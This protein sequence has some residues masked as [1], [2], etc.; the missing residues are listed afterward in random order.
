MTTRCLGCMENFNS[1]LRVCPHCGYVIGTKAE[2]AIHIV[3]GTVIKERYTIGKVLGYGGFGVTYIGWD[4]RLEQKVAI[5]EYLPSEF[6]TRMPGQSRITVFGGAKAEQFGDGLRKFVDEAKRLANF[7]NEYG[8]VKIF[9]S[10]LENDTAYIVME[11]LDGETLT[12]F[13]D[14]VGV[15]QEEEAV[16][17]LMPIMNS[18]Q[19]VHEIGLLH[20]DIAPDNIFLTRD[21][22]VK[23]IDFGASRFA[24]TSHSRSLTAI[25]K[26]G[27]SPEEQYRS[28]GDQ[29]PHTDVYAL[30]ATLYRMITGKRPP[31][32]MGRREQY[33]TANKD[34]LEAPH[35]YA[36]KISRAR[37]IAILNAM[38]VR[39]EDRTATV[40]DFISELEAD[41]PAKRRYGKIKKIDLYHWPLWL[42][43]LLPTL[44]TVIVAF[45][46][47]LLTGVIDFSV[48]VNELPL[49][50][51]VVLVPNVEQT[52]RVSAIDELKNVGLNPKIGDS[53]ESKYVTAGYVVF[54]TPIG[55]SYAEIGDE[56]ELSI[57]YD[58][59][60]YE[61]VDNIAI[62]PYVE[63]YEIKEAEERL[64]QSGLIPKINE[65]YSDEV[66]KGKVISQSVGVFEETE[67]NSEIILIVSKGPEPFELSNFV[68]EKESKEI[69]EKLKELGLSFKVIYENSEDVEKGI[70]MEQNPEAGTEVVRGEKI[71]LVI[72]AGKSETV[73]VPDVIGMSSSEAETTLKNNDFKVAIVQNYS[74]SVS[75][76][77]VISTSL[78][79]GTSQMR[80]VT[81]SVFVS[82]GKAPEVTTTEPATTVPTTTQPTTTK[83]TTTKPTTTKPTTTQPTT[84]IAISGWVK[85]SEVPAGGTVTERKWSYDITTKITSDK[86]YVDGY[87]LYDTTTSWSDYGPW[88]D[89]SRTSVTETDSRD[90][91]YKDVPATYKTQYNY[92]RYVST[93]GSHWAGPWKGTWSGNYCHLYQERGWSDTRLA[94]TGRDGWGSTMFDIFG[95]AGDGSWYNETTRSVKTADGY[96]L[97]CYRDRHLIYTYHH[98]KVESKESTSYPSGSNISNV[99]EWVKYSY[100]VS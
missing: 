6:S 10:F 90:V 89:W 28:R 18:L 36:K 34:I 82:K 54:Q 15:L 26:P 84:S 97:Y 62:V 3:P 80:G 79:S 35:K 74:E 65:E 47:L 50:D 100:V 66:E 60:V 96:R 55:G 49:A 17:M 93:D 95:G 51:G 38:N 63:N 4:S 68:G 72:S 42:K 69:K 20:R 46:G 52:D 78:K 56:I 91:D 94:I 81:I 48:F 23:L 86:S 43:V 32:A 5:K 39:I 33:E 53:F 44:L 87:N 61:P 29:G 77:K 11:Y 12:E 71:T 37:E 41:P 70:I 7:K 24:T 99:Q 25:I 83:P 22:G 76:G 58:D 67:V 21:G 57:G 14:K 64:K 19:T 73:I 30:G 92:T 75:Y 45:T 13:L 88:S 16:Q 9:D 98:S 31:D 27:Y 59:T 40:T 2:E 8:I 85:A 1:D